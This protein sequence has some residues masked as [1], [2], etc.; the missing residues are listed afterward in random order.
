MKRKIYIAFFAGLLLGAICTTIAG[1]GHGNTLPFFLL[2]PFSYLGLFGGGQLMAILLGLIQYPLYVIIIEKIPN[3]YVGV[4]LV[5][6]LH[7]GL[8]WLFYTFKVYQ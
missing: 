1:G 2:F 3:K 5:V 4:G 7:V 6:L 8:L